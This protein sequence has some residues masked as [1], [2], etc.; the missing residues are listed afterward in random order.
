MVGAMSNHPFVTTKFTVDQICDILADKV[1]TI[2]NSRL[3]HSYYGRMEYVKEF[4][5]AIPDVDSIFGIAEFA[6]NGFVEDT[7]I[8]E[9]NAGKG[10]WAYLLQL[11]LVPVIPTDSNPWKDSFTRIEKMDAASAVHR[12]KPKILMTIWPSYDE[13]Y[14][15]V[16]LYDFLR[17]GGEKLI[18]V[19]ESEGGC[20]A[21]RR[22]HEILDK[23]FT[24]E[25]VIYNPC[26]SGI[27]DSVTLYERK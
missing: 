20:T 17:F 8:L 2:K 1:S 15:T 10:L 9:I 24:V 7:T 26:F 16:A 13:S 12:F 19:G 3:E 27:Y 22:F 14:A 18:Y 5:W 11:A 21:D 25:R 6:T 4:G 23:D